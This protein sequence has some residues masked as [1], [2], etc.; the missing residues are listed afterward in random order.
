V[1]TLVDVNVL[2]AAFDSDHDHHAA[3]RA[4]IEDL[5]T[6]P[7]Q[8][9]LTSSVLVSTM[10]VLTQPHALE[11]GIAS[12]DVAAFLD[13]LIEHPGSMRVEPS[14]RFWTL[15]RAT[16]AHDGITGKLV[17]DAALAALAIEHGFELLSFDHDF[18]RFPDLRWREPQ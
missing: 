12:N 17:P 15:F 8:L 4:A 6:Q 3:A 5:V 1:P 14:A 9:A 18:S 16:C 11:R 2:I 10:R 7:S 13:E